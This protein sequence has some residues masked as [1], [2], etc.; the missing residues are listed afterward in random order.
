MTVIMDS[1]INTVDRKYS[2]VNAGKPVTRVL[3]RKQKLGLLRLSS[4]TVILPGN[5]YEYL[6]AAT[7][8]GTS[9]SSNQLEQP[10]KRPKDAGTQFSTKLL[11]CARN[12]KPSKDKNDQ[13][14]PNTVP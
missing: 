6:M 9:K 14:F 3:Q 12:Q 8:S 4:L 5:T 7:R 2:G 11:T 13:F 10:I 1:S